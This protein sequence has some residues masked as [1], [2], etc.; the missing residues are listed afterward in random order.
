MSG[1]GEIVV[2]GLGVASPIGIGADAFW[3]SL[4]AGTSGVALSTALESPLLPRWLA[5]E[6]RDFDPLAFVTP[7]KSLKVMAR[8]SQ[9]ALAAARLAREHA[10]AT[11]ETFDPDR[12]ATVFGADTINPV[13][14][15]SAQTY[16]P[17]VSGG[18]FHFERWTT[19]GMPRTYPL[20]MLKLL[21]NMLTCHVS[22]AQDARGPN[23]TIYQGDVS[24][25]LALAEAA[26]VVERGMADAVLTGGAS[27]R[28][29]P[30]D[31]DRSELVFE[32]SRR[33]DDPGAA[34]RPFDADR[35]GQV[36]A[37]G[38]A[39]LL[40]ENRR[41]ALARGATVLARLAGW[42]SSCDLP[43]EQLGRGLE[44]AIGFALARAG[45]KPSDVGHV[46]AHGLSTVA[47]DQIE[48]RALNA[49]LPGVPLTAPKS[50]FGNLGAAAG[51]IETMVS[52]LALANNLV[53]PTLNHRRTDPAC[54]V[55]VLREPL[56]GTKPV[57]VVVNRAIGGQAAALVLTAA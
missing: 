14:E 46:N 2:T 13:L 34:S 27:S 1:Q 53:P 48:A 45:L 44:R 6:V 21:P 10:A 9:L 32:L 28:M 22:I 17:C 4:V 16:G 35:D 36:R 8:D 18:E 51:A 3:R 55:T 57:A 26:S 52:V 38:S 25:L 24:G 49:V 56:A 50:Y 11:G 31:W 47:D 7:R 20:N 33:I 29:R 12:L 19:D 43:G 23:N 39:C 30:L 40:I 54:P 42:G 41:H 37:E 15:D 5:A